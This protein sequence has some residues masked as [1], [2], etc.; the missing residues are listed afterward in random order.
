M[1][2]IDRH[3]RGI[4]LQDHPLHQNQCA[5]QT[6]KSTVTTLAQHENT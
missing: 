5:Y 4:L 6:E 2:F 1:T 3:I